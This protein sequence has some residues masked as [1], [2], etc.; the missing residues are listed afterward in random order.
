MLSKWR[1]QT[2]TGPLS[3][4]ARKCRPFGRVPEMFPLGLSRL[5]DLLYP[6]IMLKRDSMRLSVIPEHQLWLEA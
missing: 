3:V 2:V 1:H 6:Q 5:K 4:E